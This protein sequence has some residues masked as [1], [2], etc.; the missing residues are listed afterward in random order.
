MDLLKLAVVGQQAWEKRH[1]LMEYCHFRL[2]LLMINK[3]RDLQLALVGRRIVASK[4]GT[5]GIEPECARAS[6]STSTN[7]TRKLS[8]LVVIVGLVGHEHDE[9]RR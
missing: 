9:T 1:S 7:L 5:V 3:A 6:A 8:S 4:V 2:S